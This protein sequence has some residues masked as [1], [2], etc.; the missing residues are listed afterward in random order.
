MT[1]ESTYLRKPEWLKIRLPRGE[2][3]AKVNSLV[4]KYGL[5]TICTSGN[6]P[7]HA[8]CWERGTATLMILGDTCTRS[9]KFCNVHTG[10]P[11]PVNPD[12]PVNVAQT[13]KEL[14]LKHCVLTSVDRDDLPDGGANHWAETI[15]QVKRLN[16]GTTIE[17]LIPDFDGKQE[18]IQLVIDAA[19]E[20]ISHNLE[21]VRRLTPMIRSR[22][23]YETSLKV[24]RH[25][26][27]NGLTAKSGIM[28]GLGETEDEILQTMDDLLAVN[29]KVFTLGQYLQ[30]TRQNYPVKEYVTP[31]KFEEYRKIGLSKGFAFVESAPLVRSSY[32]A[33]KHVVKV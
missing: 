23:K 2:E 16:P 27:D 30:P 4:K 11:L 13:V 10:K 8:D 1:S 25:I 17:T 9:C 6:C 33:E 21:T 29:C 15:C 31:E 7:N 18:L 20:V 32:R 22:A 19:P 14:G 5:H 26:A 3:F 24:L 12:E 28:L